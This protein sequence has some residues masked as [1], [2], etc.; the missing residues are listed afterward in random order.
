MRLA[1]AGLAIGITGAVTLIGGLVWYFVSKPTQSASLQHG[2]VAHV[3]PE[4]GPGYG[5]LGVAGRF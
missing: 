3:S 1:N 2:F 5:G 4:V